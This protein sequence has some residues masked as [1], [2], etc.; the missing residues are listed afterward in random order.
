MGLTVE[1]LNRVN[2]FTLDVQWHVDNELAVLFGYSG[3]G[4]SMTFH[5]IAGLTEP[6]WGYVRIHE[7]VVCDSEEKVM[8]PAHRRR[9]GYVFQDLALFPHMRVGENILYG[10]PGLDR[11]TQKGSEWRTWF[12][13]FTFKDWKTNIL[14]NFQVGRNSG[15]PF[16]RALIGQPDALLLDEPF[17]SLGRTDSPGNEGAFEGGS[18][19][20]YHSRYSYHP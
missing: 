1:L 4:K 7:K 9:L 19:N 20:V 6:D 8:V 11:E 2:G 18:Q 12:V 5:C 3:S 13:A 17:S 16:A 10:A 15:S 14:S